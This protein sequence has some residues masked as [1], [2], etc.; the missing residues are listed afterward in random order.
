VQ[1]NSGAMWK[2]APRHRLRALEWMG[3]SSRD[4]SSH[5]PAWQGTRAPG[6]N[7]QRTQAAWA[8]RCRAL[9]QWL[10]ISFLEWASGEVDGLAG[11]PAVERRRMLPAAWRTP[12]SQWRATKRRGFPGYPAPRLAQIGG[13]GLGPISTPAVAGA[14]PIS[15]A[16]RAP[17]DVDGPAGAP[18]AE[19]KMLPPAGAQRTTGDRLADPT[20][21]E[22]RGRSRQKG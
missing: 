20:A 10:L 8:G 19:P 2:D 17:E 22:P 15:F 18:A 9:L 14:R 21:P 16:E 1:A 6:R 11:A 4:T 5:L 12:C 3:Q 13:S 7:P